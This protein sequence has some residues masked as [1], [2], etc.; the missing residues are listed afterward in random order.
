MVVCPM[1]ASD[2]PR[3]SSEYYGSYIELPRASLASATAPLIVDE[4]ER[5]SSSFIGRRYVFKRQSA[6]IV[7]ASIVNMF[8]T[9][10]NASHALLLLIPKA[11]TAI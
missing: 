10:V 11:I 9:A 7:L 1:S 6:G 2:L 3:Q 5:E 8:L 4:K